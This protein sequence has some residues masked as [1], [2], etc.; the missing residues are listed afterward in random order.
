[1]LLSSC[2]PPSHGPRFLVSRLTFDVSLPY[3]FTPN[4]C[5]A[6]VWI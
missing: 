3:G 1:M 4:A 5:C 6:A 2:L